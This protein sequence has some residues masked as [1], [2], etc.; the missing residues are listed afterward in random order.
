MGRT[1]PTRTIPTNAVRGWRVVFPR[2]SPASRRQCPRG[3]LYSTEERFPSEGERKPCR[4]GGGRGIL[5]SSSLPEGGISPKGFPMNLLRLGA[6]ILLGSLPMTLAG[7]S[8]VLPPSGSEASVAGGVAFRVQTS[9]LDTL[10]SQVDSLRVQVGNGSTTRS[11]QVPVAGEA[12]ID[13]LAQGVWRVDV[14]LL[15]LGSLRYQGFAFVTVEPGK[16][17]MAK[18]ILHALAGNLQVEV[19]VDPEGGAVH[20]PEAL[21][22][23]W[24]LSDLAA[25]TIPAEGPHP[26]LRFEAEGA[27]GMKGICGGEHRGSW[28]ADDTLLWLDKGAPLTDLMNCK[29][30]PEAGAILDEVSALSG[31]PLRWSITPDSRRLVLSEASTGAWI[32]RFDPST[33]AFP[34]TD[35]RSLLGTWY[36]SGLAAEAFATIEDTIPF[37]ILEDGTLRGTDGCNSWG[38]SWEVVDETTIRLNPGPRTRMACFDAQGNTRLH[39]EVSGVV[40]WK[41][42]RVFGVVGDI[43][44]LTLIDPATNQAL[45]EYSTLAPKT[46]VRPFTG[47]ATPKGPF[48]LV[49]A[50][51][52]KAIPS[53]GIAEGPGST[54]TFDSLGRVS[55]FIGCNTHAGTWR[56][57]DDSRLVIEARPTSFVSC[58]EPL[59]LQADT[60][61][62]RM[63]SEPLDWS[64][65]PA[66]DSSKLEEI[67]VSSA[68]SGT[69]LGVFFLARFGVS[70]PSAGP[71]DLVDTIIVRERKVPDI[72]RYP[73]DLY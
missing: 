69:A 58:T 60:L 37:Q 20:L 22:G 48:D 70:Y 11:I 44:K 19:G 24:V 17:A 51:G 67:A 14:E 42:G 9:Q 7:C 15:Q 54:I 56:L 45:A 6:L 71:V 33:P 66:S 2:A 23:S 3:S 55:G 49:G 40:I 18:V 53:A 25:R 31:T 73:W 61:W 32:A 36:L 39:G 38:G 43:R 5:L 65:A 28:V 13:G 68:I 57:D 47:P 72:P 50:W 4:L 30:S 46:P 35:L 41:V 52:L 8:E 12:R 1:I 59:A 29:I 34:S 10:A 27:F 26:E 16:T 63:I 21:V 64:L 62:M